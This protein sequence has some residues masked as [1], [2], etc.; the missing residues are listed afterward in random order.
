MMM[1]MHDNVT[2]TKPGDDVSECCQRTVDAVGFSSLLG[3]GPQR[4]HR[5]PVYMSRQRN[6]PCIAQFSPPAFRA[7]TGYCL[8]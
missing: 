5:L 6:V 7:M 1:M 4:T 2:Q 3:A 8:D